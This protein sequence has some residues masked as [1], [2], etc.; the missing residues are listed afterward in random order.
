MTLAFDAVG[1]SAAGQTATTPASVTWSHTVTGSQTALVVFVGVG[2]NSG[3]DATKTISGVTYN[4][5]AMTQIGTPKHTNNDV[6]G[7]LACYGL[8]APASGANNVVVTFAS[9]PSVAECASLSFTGAD[10]TAPFGTPVTGA[11]DSATATAAVASN[12]SGNLIAFGVCCGS[13]TGTNPTSPATKR[14]QAN[15]SHSSA[16]GCFGA[17]TI[18]ATGSSVTCSWAVTSDFWALIAVEVKAAGAGGN[19]N[20]AGV[21]AETDTAIA[22]G[23]VRVTAAATATEIDSG[24]S[25]GRARAAGTAAETDTGVDAAR[26]R[27]TAAGLAGETDTAIDAGRI[28]STAAGVAVETDTAL[29]PGRTRVTTAGVSGETDVALAAGSSGARPAGQAAELDVAL[30]AGRLRVTAAGV[31]TETDQ[32]LPAARTR[33]VAAAAATETDVALSA[34]RARTTGAGTA[35]ETDQGQDAGDPNQVMRDL[36]WSG[37]VEPGRWTCS[38]EPDRWVGSVEPDR[39]LTEVEA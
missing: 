31:A 38:V 35:V 18:P 9:A 1:P 20:P 33:I 32:G 17:A 15:F 28:R 39:W 11:A 21:A 10:Q 5:V 4:G 13:D 27:V 22:A 29:P 24:L 36:T 23:R 30:P 8:I 14:A 34:G 3:S 6:F 12:T 26:I 16:G 7:Y 19:S 37:S 2:Q 25:A